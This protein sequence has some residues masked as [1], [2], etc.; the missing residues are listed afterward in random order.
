MKLYNISGE[1]INDIISNTIYETR[2]QRALEK[3]EQKHKC[4]ILY[5]TLKV[6]KDMSWSVRAFQQ[7]LKK[8]DQKE[9]G[10]DVPPNKVDLDKIAHEL[11]QGLPTF[12]LF[13][14]NHMRIKAPKTYALL[15]EKYPLVK[16]YKRVD[17]STQ[18]PSD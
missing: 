15:I 12:G 9:W 10:F 14:I 8:V 7:P 1:N 5:D 2:T 13:Y 16:D 4:I 11:S 17:I 3:L 6:N 18:S